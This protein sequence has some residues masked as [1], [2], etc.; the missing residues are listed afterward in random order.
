MQCTMMLLVKYF[1]KPSVKETL[2][3]DLLL[4]FILVKKFIF[5]MHLKVGASALYLFLLMLFLMPKYTLE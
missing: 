5:S 4:V 2:A 3:L 1:R